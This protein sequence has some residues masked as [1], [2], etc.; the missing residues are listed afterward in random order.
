MNWA[1]P[2]FFMITGAL[3][4]NPL[5]EIT[6]EKSVEKYAMRIFYPLF[7][8]GIMNM[9][10]IFG[11]QLHDGTKT[12][13]TALLYIYVYINNFAGV[14]DNIL[15]QCGFIALF[16]T[17]ALMCALAY[18]ALDDY[19]KK[20]AIEGKLLGLFMIGYIVSFFYLDFSVTMTIFA[21]L[22]AGCIVNG[23]YKAS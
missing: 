17:I 4:L 16:L 2:V 18:K 15:S 20:T 3:L 7:F 14:L 6:I 8:W 13:T 19:R 21:S 10:D 5:K 1:V 9:N 11:M 12:V 22:M 23:D